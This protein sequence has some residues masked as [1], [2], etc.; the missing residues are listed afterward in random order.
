MS[1]YDALEEH[2][3]TYLAALDEYEAVARYECPSY[4][5]VELPKMYLGNALLE[6]LGLPTAP[7]APETRATPVSAHLLVYRKATI[8]TAL[9]WEVFER[10]DFRCQICSVRRELTVDH[11]HP[12][13][14]GGTL[15]IGNL[16]TLCRSC[17]SR[18]GARV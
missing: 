13:R 3:E 10:D 2:I 8:P 12:E 5:I 17:N 16:Q 6:V 11:I 14:L 7:K 9:K 18:K 4:T 1:I 15:D